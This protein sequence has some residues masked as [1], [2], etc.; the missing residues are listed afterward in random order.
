[1]KS[2]GQAAFLLVVV[3]VPAF[4]GLC[5]CNPMTVA[6]EPSTIGLVATG[7]ATIGLGAWI[8]RNRR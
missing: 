3:A 7:V 2:I 5:D 6:P 1:M 4:A 8:N